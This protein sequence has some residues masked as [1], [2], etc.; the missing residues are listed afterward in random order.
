[1]NI[2]YII[3]ALLGI[4]KQV[5]IIALKVMCIKI[6][7]DKGLSPEQ[8][9]IIMAVISAES[10]WNTK[11][12]N[13]NTDNSIDYGLCQY[14]SYWYIEKMDLITKW[15]ALNDYKKCIEVMVDRYKGGNLKDWSAYKF[16]TYKKFL[17]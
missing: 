7:R 15:E 8:T 4:K 3:Q 2:K 17:V 5:D 1:M 9:N 6:C 11:A 13:K 16:G 12:V 14:N 10:G